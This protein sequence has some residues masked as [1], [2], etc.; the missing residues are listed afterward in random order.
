MNLPSPIRHLSLI[1]ATHQHSPLGANAGH[2]TLTRATD[3]ISVVRAWLVRYQNAP[4]TFDAY[5]REAE[6]LLMWCAD[7]GRGLSEL[8]V[9]DMSAYAKFLRDPQPVERWCVVKVPRY[10][11]DGTEN[12]AW[13]TV[14]RP[15]RFLAN[16][17]ANPLWRPFIGG[18]S[19]TA[20]SQSLIICNNLF[21]W[22]AA[23]G[24]LAGNPLRVMR[25]RGRRPRKQSVER[26][27]EQDLWQFVLMHLESWPQNTPREA[28]HYQRTRFLVG[29][30]K[31]TAL[32]RFELAKATTADIQRNEGKYWLKV[33][34]KGNVEQAIPLTTESINLL[35]SYRESTGRTGLPNPAVVE[36]L[37][38][39]IC[40]VGRPVSTKTIHAVLKDLFFSASQACQDHFQK[41]KLKAASAH[42][43]RHTAATHL[44][45]QG[46]DLLHT[47]DALRHASVQTTEIYLHT[48]Q[49]A[50]QADLEENQKL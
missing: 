4:Q 19:D 21:E 33:K 46:V 30:L 17:E 39:D 26:Y 29:F 2:R 38:M 44:L 50:F 49:I 28:A 1:A 45:Q 13:K 22:L 18:L 40:G 37:L 8:M 11:E 16:D 47:R 36:P 41:E 20:R 34:G 48:N 14:Q 15:P 5:R 35:C 27:L 43:L 3:D 31:L 25:T 10:R 23:T 42:W 24:Y 7:Q 32:R 6:R 12:P 9:E